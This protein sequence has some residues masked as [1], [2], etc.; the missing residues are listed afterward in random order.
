MTSPSRSATLTPLT[1]RVGDSVKSGPVR[2]SGPF[3]RAAARSCTARIASS[4]AE[5]ARRTGV[6]PPTASAWV[7]RRTSSSE[8]TVSNPNRR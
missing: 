7:G 5:V 8:E 4:S 3:S 2:A 6:L 1:R